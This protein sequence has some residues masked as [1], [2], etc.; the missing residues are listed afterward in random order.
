MKEQNKITVAEFKDEFNM[1]LDAY[2]EVKTESVQK[3]FAENSFKFTDFK[4]VYI[5]SLKN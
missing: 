5:A 2:L 3:G 4:E 1:L